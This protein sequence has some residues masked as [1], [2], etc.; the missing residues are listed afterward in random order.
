MAAKV[1]KGHGDALINASGGAGI[2]EPDQ[3]FA[4]VKLIEPAASRSRSPEMYLLAKDF[5]LV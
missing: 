4:K 5:R 2:Q 3:D 1:L